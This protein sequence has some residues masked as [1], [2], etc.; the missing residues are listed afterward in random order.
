MAAV[1]VLIALVVIAGLIAHDARILGRELRGEQ[2]SMAAVLFDPAFSRP[3]RRG[4]W[5]LVYATAIAGVAAIHPMGPVRG[6]VQASLAM[7]ALIVL[8]IL[9]FSRP[10]AAAWLLLVAWAVLAVFL[11]RSIAS[12]AELGSLARLVLPLPRTPGP[13]LHLWWLYRTAEPLP[14]D[15]WL[16]QL[17]AVPGT[18]LMIWLLVA[19]LYGGL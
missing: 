12:P 8:T 4:S 7:V 15:A 19:S 11:V 17:A 6:P 14:D 18:P 13:L 1:L 10:R 3:Q 9:A 2:G 16:H 5:A